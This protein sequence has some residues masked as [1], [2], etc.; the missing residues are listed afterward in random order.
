[1]WS[2][3]ADKKNIRMFKAYW[4]TLLDQD[5]LAID[6]FIAA[7]RSVGNV[8]NTPTKEMYRS[9]SRS[10]NDSLLGG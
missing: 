9:L 2:Y 1:M 4:D 3:W 5:K 6:K 10:E 8:K 7:I